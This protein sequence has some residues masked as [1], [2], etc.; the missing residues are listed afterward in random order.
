MLLPAESKPFSFRDYG[1]S[2]TSHTAS[3]DLY[4]QIQSGANIGGALL[5]MSMPR[6]DNPTG[7]RSVGHGAR[8]EEREQCN[9]CGE[10]H[11][12]NE[13]VETSRKDGRE[14]SKRRWVLRLLKGGRMMSVSNG[15]G[16]LNTFSPSAM[17]PPP[18]LNQFRESHRRG[19]TAGWSSRA[20][21]NALRRGWSLIIGSSTDVRASYTGTRVEPRERIHYAQS[22]NLETPLDHWRI[23]C[24]ATHS[25]GM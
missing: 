20:A 12:E 25:S 11:D 17:T 14:L 24:S 6:L 23:K 4:I 3:S 19:K 16:G 1:T 22:R 9:Q 2:T 13:D 10:F 8:E 21:A 5:Y 15:Q 7:H 18:P